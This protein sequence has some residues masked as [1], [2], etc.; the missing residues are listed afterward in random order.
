MVQGSPRVT[1]VTG[2]GKN[3][4]TSGGNDWRGAKRIISTDVRGYTKHCEDTDRRQLSRLPLHGLGFGPRC[5]G[6]D[7]WGGGYRMGEPDFG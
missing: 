5:G 4:K 3:G 2:T 6:Q 7:R 1:G